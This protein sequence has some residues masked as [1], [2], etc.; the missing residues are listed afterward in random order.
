MITTCVRAQKTGLEKPLLC[1]AQAM[2]GRL[3]KESS[4]CDNKEEGGNVVVEALASKTA[5]AFHIAID[6]VGYISP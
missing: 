4:S 5:C 6:L 1:F 2:R 3:W